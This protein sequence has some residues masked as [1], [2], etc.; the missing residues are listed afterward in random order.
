ME[1]IHEGGVD[2]QNVQHALCRPQTRDKL[3]F[4]NLQR[5]GQ[6]GSL[7]TKWRL[8]LKLIVERQAL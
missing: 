3:W 1:G 7:N 2:G 4:K 6:L 5:E 8:I